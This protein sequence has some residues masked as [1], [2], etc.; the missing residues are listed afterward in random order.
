MPHG[1]ILSSRVSRKEVYT[2]DISTAFKLLIP[3]W[4]SV[5]G[6][7]TNPYKFDLSRCAGQWRC[8][9]VSRL[10]WCTWLIVVFTGVYSSWFIIL[11]LRWWR[12]VPN[13]FDYESVDAPPATTSFTFLFRRSTLNRTGLMNICSIWWKCGLI[14]MYL[15]EKLLWIEL[16]FLFLLD[17]NAHLSESLS[18]VFLRPMWIYC[19]YALSWLAKASA[20][21]LSMNC[22]LTKML[23]KTDYL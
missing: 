1:I 15:C 5:K 7:F 13:T 11:A 17:W 3:I 4:Y 19:I 16:K 10:A 8:T 2:G 12:E 23:P 9:F 14:H 21:Y 6:G 18:T 22:V 20:L